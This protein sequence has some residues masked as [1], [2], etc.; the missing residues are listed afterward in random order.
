M[1]P[2]STSHTC[3]FL[4]TL[5]SRWSTFRLSP[6]CSR[7]LQK[8][9]GW[10]AE[11][12]AIGSL[13]LV[14]ETGDRPMPR[15]RPPNATSSAYRRANLPR[16]VGSSSNSS[17]VDG[18]SPPPPALLPQLTLPGSRT[19][20][21]EFVT[22]IEGAQWFVKF[23]SAQAYH[24][25]READWWKTSFQSPLRHF[26]WKAMSFRANFG[27]QGASSVL[28]PVMNSTMSKG[29]HSSGHSPESAGPRVVP[30]A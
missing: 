6:P 4:D 16:F 12:D 22:T 2:N 15:T 20:R 29:L 13:E 21:G 30:V 7:N 27:L 14:L 11:W 17:T 25:I 8:C 9:F 19:G 5:L 28:F 24:R 23:D 3:G 26:E 18:F 1:V 10:T